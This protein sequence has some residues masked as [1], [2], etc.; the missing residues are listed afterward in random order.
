MAILLMQSIVLLCTEAADQPTFMREG[1]AKK[2][3]SKRRQPPEGMPSPEEMDKDMDDMH[4]FWCKTRAETN[5]CKLWY[6]NE[7]NRKMALTEG[8]PPPPP[9][10][11]EQADLKDIG[12][13]HKEWCSVDGHHKRGPCLMWN[14]SPIKEKYKNEHDSL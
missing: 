9:E 10:G 3:R 1:K 8:K 7:K 12:D 14:E 4:E 6:E 2:N 5:L 13:M 11:G